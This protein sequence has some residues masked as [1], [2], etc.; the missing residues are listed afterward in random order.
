VDVAAVAGILFAV[1]GVEDFD[2]LD[3]VAV[4][5]DVCLVC[6][7]NEDVAFA[8]SFVTTELFEATDAASLAP[9]LNRCLV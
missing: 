8:V 3:V 6:A 4:T 1:F 2:T 5:T 7:G 9:I